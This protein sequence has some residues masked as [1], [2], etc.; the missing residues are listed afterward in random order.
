VSF[1]FFCSIFSIS[2]C[3]ARAEEYRVQPGDDVSAA[4]AGLKA[5]DVLLVEPGVYTNHWQIPA[6]K[7]TAEKPIIIRGV[8]NRQQTGEENP[9][10][11]SLDRLGTGGTEARRGREG[12]GAAFPFVPNRNPA[13]VR[14]RERGGSGGFRAIEPKTVIRPV[15]G[16]DGIVF[17]PGKAEHVVLENI[18][19]ENA[20]RGGI[21]VFDSK[22]IAIRNCEVVS[23]RVWG[24]QTCLSDYITVSNCAAL[25]SIEEHGVYFSTTDHPMVVDSRIVGNKCCGIHLNAGLAEGGDGMITGGIFR[26]NL[27]EGNGRG[28]GAAI[29]MD[30]V[31]RSVVSG[32]VLLDNHAG[33]IVNFCQDGKAVGSS[34]RIEGNTIYFA[35]GEGRYGIGMNGGTGNVCMSNS[36]V[37]GS[38]PALSVR[39]G[40]VRGLVSD[41]NAFYVHGGGRIVRRGVWWY[42]LKSWQKAFKRDLHSRM[43]TKKEV[44]TIREKWG[45]SEGDGSVA[46]R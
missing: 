21:V 38:G 7:G 40:T 14:S 22:H 8:G 11:P 28:G 24:I 30:G 4:L 15:N 20:A 12:D 45:I 23:N 36:V 1:V 25:G 32:N 27:I 29:N 13:P 26:N 46:R 9:N 39:R 35:P 6:L 43:L 33:G 37:I 2:I 19:V 17:W 44:E 34:N 42:G 5:G 3:A 31:E 41:H 10:H 18:R 16:R